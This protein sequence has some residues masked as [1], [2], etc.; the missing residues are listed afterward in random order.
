MSL[1]QALATSLSGLTATQTNLSVVAGNVANAQTP[2]YI[3]L[4]AVQV[5]TVGGNGG[6]GVNIASIN[7]LLDQFVQQ[8]IALRKFRR[9][10]RRPEGQFLSAASANLRSARFQ[11]VARLGLQQLHLGDTGLVDVA[12]FVGGAKPDDRRCASSWR[13]S[14]TMR[15]TASKR[16]AA[17]PTRA[18]RAMFSRPT[19]PC[20]RSRASISSWRAAVRP[21]ACRLCLKTSAINTSINWPS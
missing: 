2:G 16:C 18:S 3:A 15:R 9:G 13:S 4:S 1:T 17:R 10:L 12:K 21:T 6:A 19:T 7:R 11:Y 14:S 20:S 8:A 5:A